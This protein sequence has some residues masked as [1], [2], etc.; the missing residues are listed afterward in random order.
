MAGFSDD[1]LR[2][3]KAN[4]SDDNDYRRASVDDVKEDVVNAIMSRFA[5]QYNIWLQIP[6]WVKNR[7][8][9]RI[10]TEVLN[11]NKSPQDLV[12]E[13][14]EKNEKTEEVVN[15]SIDITVLLMAIGYSIETAAQLSQQRALR[16]KILAENKGVKLPP[17]LLALWLETRLNDKQAVAKD[18][19]NNQKEKYLLHLVK[20]LSREEK[21]LA[22][23]ND[24][25]KQNEAK[26][27]IAA[28][29]RELETF[30]AS[31]NEKDAAERMVNYLRQP[32][33]QAALHHMKPEV[34]AMFVDLMQK[35]GIKVEQNY[36][37]TNQRTDLG[38]GS[39]TDSLREDFKRMVDRQAVLRDAA[40]RNNIL[41]ERITASKVASTRGDHVGKIMRYSAVHKEQTA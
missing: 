33:Q 34:L 23:L 7:Y 3:L 41:A 4:F 20:S 32:A 21:A 10:P 39:L 27:K 9:D 29:K 17:E 36:Q 12:Q 30:S 24:P 25:N 16:D 8:S 22:G 37:K 2:F 1:F 14:L 35:K 26:M 19:Q 5:H 15:S 13:E 11:G 40:L 18:W 31:M 6:E 38:K 28:L